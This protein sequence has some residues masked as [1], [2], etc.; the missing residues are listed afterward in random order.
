[1]FHLMFFKRSHIKKK[2][3]TEQKLPIHDADYE[4]VINLTIDVFF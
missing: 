1:M 3:N 2:L 4:F